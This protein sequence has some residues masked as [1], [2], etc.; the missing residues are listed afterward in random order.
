MFDALIEIADHY[1]AL[2]MPRGHDR[3]R[4]ADWPKMFIFLGDKENESL[5]AWDKAGRVRRIY[6]RVANSIVHDLE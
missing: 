1:R 2:V 3:I 6:G 4:G 5:A